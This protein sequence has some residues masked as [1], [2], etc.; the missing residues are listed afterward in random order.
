MTSSPSFATSLDALSGWRS[1]LAQRLDDVA[2]FLG[3]HE[4]IDDSAGMQVSSLRERLGNEKLV[5]AF[6]AEFS[7]GKSELI[8][9]IFFADTG[10]RILP[11]T[12]GRTTMCPVELAWD[13][14]EPSSLMLLPIETRLDGLSL[15]ELRPQRRAWKVVPLQVRDPEQLAQSLLE[16]TRT[17][18]VSKEQARA[19]GFWD[20]AHPDDNPPLDDAGRVEVP[21]W[22]HALINYPHPLLKQ[23]LVVLD[24]PGL[25]A[26]GAEPELTLSL[27]PSA[28]ATV[29]ILGADTG[30]TKSDMAIW[31]DHLGSHAPT[32]FV[33]LNKIDALLD[34]LATPAAVQAQI[35]GVRRETARTLDVPPERVFPLSARQALAARVMGDMEALR[36]S[37]LPELESALGTQLLPQR[38]QVLEDVVLEGAQQIENHVARRLG[39]TRRQL[40]EQMLELRGLRGKS[41][42]KL[43]LMIER[44]DA[45]TAEFEQCTVRLQALRVVHSRMLKDA[46]VGLSSDRLREEVSEMQAVMN[47]SLLNLGAKKAFIVLCTK[48]R[49]LLTGAQHLNVEVRDMLGASFAR[50]NAEFGFSLALTKA[51]EM[52]RYIDE[53]SLIETN[54]VQY[55]GL[56]QAL[57]LSQPKFMEQFRRMLVSKLRVVFE[58]ASGDLEIWNKSTSAQVDSQLRER[59]RNFR[60]RRE[61]LERVQTAASEL[62]LRLGEIE[63]QD[64]RLQSL[65][66]RTRHLLEALREQACAGPMPEAAAQPLRAQA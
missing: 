8:N 7:R 50:L 64:E 33:V 61:S 40:A 11:A 43:R 21:A 46:L 48:L 15:T 45:E 52:E 25:N 35:A 63:T 1:A 26:I 20:D 6:V 54:Y 4:L 51:P 16:V 39:D 27:L 22:R 62:E 41:S 5:V 37:H 2:R 66:G 12:P 30:V 56:T 19:L 55:L 24:T 49:A 47:K 44:V 59:R 9:A 18:F 65:L 29:F 34:P 32:R 17:N 38:R 36:A 23:G 42:S 57:R 14:E 60:R 31:R 58:N 53:L 3:E 28:H 10:R 13:A